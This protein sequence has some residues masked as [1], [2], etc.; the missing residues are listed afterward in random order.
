M[1]RVTDASGTGVPSVTVTFAIAAGDGWVT[2]A[3]ATTD[4]SGRAATTWYLGPMPGG[5]QALTATAAGF[6]VMVSATTEP[7]A[8][9]TTYTGADM[10]VEFTA[11]D[12]PVIIS[13]PHGGTLTPGTIPDRSGSN[14]T[15]VRDANTDLLADEVRT[16]F[17]AE[18]GGSPHVIVVHLHRRKLDANREIVEAAEGNGAAERAWREYH[19]FIEAARQHVVGRHARGFYIDLHGHGH[20]VQR[21]ELGYLLSAVDLAS[22]DV[23]LNSAPLVQRSSIRT[24]AE[25]GTATHAELL[26]GAQSLGTLFELHGYAAVP[27][28][29][30]TH[31]DGAPYFTGGYNTR[32]HSSQ[33]GGLIDGVQIEANMQGVR[34]TEASREAFASAVV[35]VMDAYFTAHYDGILAGLADETAADASWPRR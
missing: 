9:G 28:T 1:V 18:T 23:T 27:S 30:Q 10:W 6:S 34:D 32:R 33:N 26:R 29:S 24:L 2:N 22:D 35:S 31:P 20:E 12:L 13:A 8:A 15:I 3:S 19:G 5:E 16:A 17:E 11:G 25:T 21:L 4:G 14:A 7:L